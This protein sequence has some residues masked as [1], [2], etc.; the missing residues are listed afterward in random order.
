MTCELD[1]GHIWDVRK[2]TYVKTFDCFRITACDWMHLVRRGHFW[3][4]DKDGGHTVGSTIAKNPMIHANLMALSLT[5]S[6]LSAI[7]VYNYIA[8][9]RNFRPFFCSC[10]LDL[11]PMTFIYELDPTVLP[12]DISNVQI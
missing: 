3:S 2:C 12:G 10:D 11:D 8:G 5:Q 6:E 1:P 7:E 4:R 9:K